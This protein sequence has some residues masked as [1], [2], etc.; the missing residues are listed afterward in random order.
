MKRNLIAFLVSF[1]ATLI[2]GYVVLSINVDRSVPGA[3]AIELI[4]RCNLIFFDRRLQPVNAF[5][6]GYPR[7]VVIRLEPLPTQQPYVKDRG[8]G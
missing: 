4:G 2:V 7:M 8:R 3:P 6:F 5:V 1:I